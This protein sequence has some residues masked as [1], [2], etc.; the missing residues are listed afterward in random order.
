MK[1][2]LGCCLL[3]AAV[4]V[5]AQTKKLYI[6]EVHNN[7]PVIAQVAAGIFKQCSSAITTTDNKPDADL[8]LMV[9]PGAST[10]YNKN[11]DVLYVSPAHTPG[12][13]AKDVCNFVVKNSKSDK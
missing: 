4:P 6:E 8:S 2:L 9:S 12:N 10:L 1:R 11:G 13:A 5:S 7:R 3:V